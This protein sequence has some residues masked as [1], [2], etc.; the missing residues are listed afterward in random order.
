MATKTI[1]LKDAGRWVASLKG[2]LRDAAEKGLL[3]AAARLVAHIQTVTIP[4]ADPQPVDRGMYKAGWRYKAIKGGAEVYNTTPQAPIIE[5]GAK[6]ANIKVGRK[7]IDALAQ[8]V[9]R[10]GIAKD[11]R[12]ARQIA[13]AIAFTMKKKG[14]FNGGKGLR[15]LE[16]ATERAPEFIRQEVDREIKRAT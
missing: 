13:F 11:E 15:I 3:S 5:Y 9:R 7:M 10:K 12:E 14:I 16:K 6:A 4:Q 2:D 8:W 1:S